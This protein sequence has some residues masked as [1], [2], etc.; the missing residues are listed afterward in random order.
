MLCIGYPTPQQRE[1]PKPPRFRVE[2]I[3]HENTYRPQG[4]GEMEQMLLRRDPALASGLAEWV[5]R[6]CARKWNSAF[7]VEM[8]RSC[9]ALICAWV[10]NTPEN[11]PES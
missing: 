3:V 11:P 6:F 7:S 5:R 2:D 8:S 10:G 1:R 9:R 4:A